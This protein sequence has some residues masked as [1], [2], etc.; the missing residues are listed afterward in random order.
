MLW[1]VDDFVSISKVFK[2][3]FIFVWLRKFQ[4]QDIYVLK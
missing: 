4:K 1:K 2:M 3:Q